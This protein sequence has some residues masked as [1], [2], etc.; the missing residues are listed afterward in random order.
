MT[1]SALVKHEDKAAPAP[2]AWSE[3]GVQIDSLD[4]AWRF[5]QYAVRSGL[6]PDSLQKPEAVVICLQAGMELGLTPWQSVQ[7]I[8]PIKGTP[9]IRVETAVALVQACGLLEPGT[10]IRHKYEGTGDALKCIVWSM[11]RGAREPVETEF[12]MADAKTAGLAGKDSWKNYPKRMLLARAKGFHVRDYYPTA[13]RRVPLA[14]EVTDIEDRRG[15]TERDVTPQAPSAKRVSSLLAKKV[16]TEAV[17]AENVPTAATAPTCAH[18]EGF[19]ADS[20]TGERVCIECGAVE[21]AQGEL[22]PG[23]A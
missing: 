23:A 10:Q 12:S 17:E 18:P 6:L 8:V 15:R 16:G 11:P 14:E 19:A 9:T 13:I 5:A 3:K 1:E 20:E 22:L 21:A 2:V 4:G 7:S